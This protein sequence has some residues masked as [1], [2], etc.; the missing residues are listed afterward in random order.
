[1][2]LY[3]QN[4]LNKKTDLFEVLCSCKVKYF[5]FV[6]TKNCYSICK[7]CSKKNYELNCQFCQA[8]LKFPEDDE[9]IDLINNS[10]KC[11]EC[12]K[13]NPGLPELKIKSY[14]KNEIPAEVWKEHDSRRFLPKWSI[15]IFIIG[16]AVFYIWKYFLK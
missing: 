16:A 6:D 3:F 7:K 12:N 13:V 10:W 15:W 9:S 4:Y 8:I 11:V 2:D 5:V 1:M 14:E